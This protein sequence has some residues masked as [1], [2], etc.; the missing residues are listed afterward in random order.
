MKKT[1]FC[2]ISV[3]GAN[4]T[5]L[6]SEICLSQVS[7]SLRPL[8]R[9]LLREIKFGIKLKVRACVTVHTNIGVNSDINF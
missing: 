3:I 8:S 5:N 7:L 6:I 4:K 2:S 9:D 1:Y